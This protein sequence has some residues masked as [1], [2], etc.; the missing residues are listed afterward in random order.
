MTAQQFIPDPF[1]QLPGKRLYKTG[2][3]ARYHADGTLEFMGRSDNQVKVRGQRVELEEIEALLKQHPVVQEAV[4]IFHE[5]GPA[6][7]RLI[8]YFT[9][10]TDQSDT[11]SGFYAYLH[12]RLPG[13]MVPG[14]VKQIPAMPLTPNGKIDRKALPF[15]ESV[16]VREQKRFIPPDTDVERLLVAI[17]QEVLQISHVGADE[18]FFE[19]GGHS[20]LVTQVRSRIREQLGVDLPLI[21]MFQ[22]TTIRALARHMSQKEDV[23]KAPQFSIEMRAERQRQVLKHRRSARR[24]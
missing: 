18:N 8:A 12:A 7:R 20:L 10:K 2:D 21:D 6:D 17:W 19:L 11:N 24:E 9:A 14:I 15:L 3:M 23:Q 16:S 13:Y 5:F 1:S 4:V 22:F